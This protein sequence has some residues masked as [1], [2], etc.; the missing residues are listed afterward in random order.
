M[1]IIKSASIISAEAYFFS[2]A[3]FLVSIVAART[4]TPSDL[5]VFSIILSIYG[6]QQSLFVAC[7]GEGHLIH[8]KEKNSSED[9]IGFTILLS[10]LMVVLLTSVLFAVFLNPLGLTFYDFVGILFS[11]LVLVT[12]QCFRFHNLAL[13]NIAVAVTCSLIII[14]AISAGW[15]I[16]GRLLDTS[17]P[18]SVFLS[19][20]AGALV[21]VAIQLQWC[22]VR[23]NKDAIR[24]LSQK[25]S[26]FIRKS[27]ILSLAIWMSS[28]LPQI[29]LGAFFN[30][31]L[32][33]IIRACLTIINP[34][35]SI[36]RGLVN[37]LLVQ[38][39][40]KELSR[41]NIFQI[42]LRY[43]SLI[44]PIHLVI[45]VLW[46]TFPTQIISYSI[47]ESYFKYED[48]ISIIIFIPLVQSLAGFSSAV[49]RS[50]H[51]FSIQTFTFVVSPIVTL[52]TFYHFRFSE[53]P[54]FI[55]MGLLLLALLQSS[56]IFWKLIDVTRR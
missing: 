44:V 54:K 32:L 8:T 14:V 1:K 6:L 13:K 27:G 30:P 16:E 47:G 43:L 41:D 38:V 23:F 36:E 25:R 35:Q 3:F 18:V 29:I 11:N 15:L 2:A 52:G 42:F 17:E 34:V 37:S 20:G 10:W 4:L 45:I 40:E 50:L 33:G 24:S 21:A 28:H 39:N 9:E 26:Q 46:F 53:T 5:G 56:L 12:F 49:L 22:K 51:F 55:F 31:A 48:A 7:L 19:M